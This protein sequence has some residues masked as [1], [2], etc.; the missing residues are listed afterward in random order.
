M[1][2]KYCKKWQVDN[3]TTRWGAPSEGLSGRTSKGSVGGGK[4]S[5]GGV[6]GR[7]QNSEV[8]K[9]PVGRGQRSEVGGQGEPNSRNSLCAQRAQLQSGRAGRWRS[10]VRTGTATRTDTDGHGRARTHKWGRWGGIVD[11]PAG[12][13]GSEGRNSRLERAEVRGRRSGGTEQPEQRLRSASAATE[14]PFGGGT[15]PVPCENRNSHTD[16]HGRAR[17]HKWGRWGGIV[18]APLGALVRRG[19]EQPVGESR[20]QRSE[21]RKNL[22]SR[23]AF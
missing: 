3:F 18:D 16:G 20:E 1:S 7:G 22:N 6:Q 12:R 19:T 15:P 4:G 9:Q 23:T 11:A 5:G 8:R 14:Q 17:T 2:K 13:I 21:V 10:R